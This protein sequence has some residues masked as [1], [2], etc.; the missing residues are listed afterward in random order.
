MPVVLIEIWGQDTSKDV[1]HKL[2]EGDLATS[3][4]KP[5]ELNES[6]KKYINIKL[7]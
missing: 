5:I 3:M 1:H 6:T 7:K 4:F 2:E